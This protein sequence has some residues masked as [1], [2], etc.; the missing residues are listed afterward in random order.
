MRAENVVLLTIKKAY[1]T[2]S[3]YE[4]RVADFVLANADETLNLTVANLAKQTQVSE[5]TVI[6]FCR[7]LNFTGYQEFKIAL[8]KGDVY[9]GET[10]KVIHEEVTPQDS[11]REISSKVISSHILAMQQTMAMI[12]YERLEQFIDLILRAGHLDFFGLGGSG[13]VA[14]D[15][16]NKFLRTGINTRCCIDA[17][18]QLIWTA[19]RDKN[20][21]IVIFSN[22]GTTRHFVKVMELARKN[23][24]K[25]VLITSGSNTVLTRLA[26][27]T[28][29][30]H[31]SETSHKKEPSSSRIAMLAIMDVVATAIA[32]EKQSDYIENIYKTRAALENEKY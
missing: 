11:V 17:H 6:R 21:V 22:S 16:E 24:V 3:D 5:P 8:A 10:L 28:F 9:G 30:I 19:L 26:D 14:M 13:T 29:Q 1:T 23:G 32:L 7:K 4:K 31:A 25:L 2:L 12:N 18:I 15:V 20:D 27:I